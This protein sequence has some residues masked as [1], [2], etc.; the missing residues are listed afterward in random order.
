[1]TSYKMLEDDDIIGDQDSD[2]EPQEV[3]KVINQAPDKW[4]KL[5]ADL[6]KIRDKKAELQEIQALRKTLE[7]K[8]ADDDANNLSKK[9]QKQMRKAFKELDKLERDNFIANLQKKDQE[10]TEQKS[11]GAIVENQD[12][13]AMSFDE[14]KAMVPALRK[15]SR[16]AYLKLRD[17]QVMELYKRNLD[18]EKRVFRDE[19]LTPAERRIAELRETLYG[20]AQKFHQK[21][22]TEKL[23]H[24]PDHEENEGQLSRQDRLFN[25]L[26]QKYREDKPRGGAPEPTEEERFQMEKELQA[27]STFGV[28]D[29][30]ARR[31]EKQYELLL[32]NQVDFVKS[33]LLTGLID[34]TKKELLKKQKKKKQSKK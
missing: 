17:E 15:Q 27:K 9:E 29:K 10:K 33:D 28:K 32:D 6:Q 34:K 7:S 24:F 1:M 5:Q 30:R 12:N 25:K 8:D 22:E 20:L 3:Q 13:A 14:L 18:E 26:N 2:Q 4:K 23:Y 21:K 19:E 31:E 16:Q 11:L